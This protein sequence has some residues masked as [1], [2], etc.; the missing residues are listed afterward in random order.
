MTAPREAGIVPDLAVEAGVLHDNAG[1]AV[2]DEASEVLIARCRILGGKLEAD[3]SGIG[4]TYLPVM[5]MKMTGEHRLAA[6]RDT[7]RHHHRLGTGRRSVVERGVRDFHPGQQRDLGL[8]LEE[9]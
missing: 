6:A 9:I 5:R 2:I 8:K 7:V 1:C 4:C 3:E